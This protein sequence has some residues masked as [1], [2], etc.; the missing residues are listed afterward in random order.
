MPTLPI[1]A[2]IPTCEAPGC[3]QKVGTVRNYLDENGNKIK[4]NYRKVCDFHHKEH[5]HRYLKHRKDY[6]ENIDGRLGFTCN[7]NLPTKE[8]LEQAGILLSPK[9]F[10]TVDH[11]NGCPK[12][13]REENLQTLCVHCHEIKSIQNKDH[14]TPGRNELKGKVLNFPNQ[15]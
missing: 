8:M 10:L 7:T 5:Y 4:A 12:D 6:C 3:K 14:L 9:Q 2:E 11:I 1:T 15:T 13:D